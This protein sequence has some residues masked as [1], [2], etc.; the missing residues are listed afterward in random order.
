M[1]VNNECFSSGLNSSNNS[2]GQSENNVVVI[3]NS[4]IIDSNSKLNH[5][6]I[7]NGKRLAATVINEKGDFCEKGSHRYKA[8]IIG[9]LIF[10]FT[11]SV[12]GHGIEDD[13]KLSRLEE[14]ANLVKSFQNRIDSGEKVSPQA[15][16]SLFLQKKIIERVGSYTNQSKGKKTTLALASVSSMILS[17]A[18]FGL[19][20]SLSILDLMQIPLNL[21]VLGTSVSLLSGRYISQP[22]AREEGLKDSWQLLA[23]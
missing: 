21:I 9:G 23:T 10:G 20:N 17:V 7:T 12:I 22:N 18:Q 15:E 16:Q 3:N 8:S 1:L 19:G 2:S 14:E 11:G 4:T 6:I 5:E 13:K